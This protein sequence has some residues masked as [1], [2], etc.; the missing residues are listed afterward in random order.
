MQ[1]FFFSKPISP[2]GFANLLR[3]NKADL[4]EPQ[5]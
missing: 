4:K 3:K 2:E 5:S 1:G